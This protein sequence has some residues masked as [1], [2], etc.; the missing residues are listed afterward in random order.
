MR[1]GFEQQFLFGLISNWIIKTYWSG[2]N[3][4]DSQIKFHFRFET[5]LFK[6]L[7]N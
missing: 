6:I 2:A 7:V 4:E 3:N 1:H 5:E